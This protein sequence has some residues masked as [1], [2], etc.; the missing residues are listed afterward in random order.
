MSMPNIPDVNPEINICKDDVIN[1]IYMS[2]AMQ[3]ISLSHILNAEGE[4]LQ[5]VIA[6]QECN[7]CLKDLININESVNS[8]ID[9]IHSLEK[10]LVEKVSLIKEV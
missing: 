5:Q 1:I 7:Y 6:N 2:I 10:I 3:E 4:L 8:I 9:K